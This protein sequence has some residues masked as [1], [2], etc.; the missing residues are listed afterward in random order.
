MSRRPIGL[1][2]ELTA[3]RVRILPYNDDAAT[4]KNRRAA[5]L[6][7]QSKLHVILLKESFVRS[8]RAIVNARQRVETRGMIFFRRCA[9][10]EGTRK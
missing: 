9:A 5:P 2:L 6:W 7:C 4:W 1:A 3:A 8:C 10:S